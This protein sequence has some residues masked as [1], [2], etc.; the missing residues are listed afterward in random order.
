MDLNNTPS[1]SLSLI[2]PKQTKLVKI[3]GVNMYK[4]PAIDVVFDK[5]GNFYSNKR[6]KGFVQLLGRKVHYILNVDGKIVKGNTT[7]TSL[8][9]LML[10]IDQPQT[11]S[12]PVAK[13][14][15]NMFDVKIDPMMKALKES[16][17]TKNLDKAMIM[18]RIIMIQA[19]LDEIKKLVA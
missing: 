12:K 14:Q 15:T 19:S 4:N 7:K 2:D 8:H 13:K 17:K 9:R 16:S 11:K 1:K 3:N 6:Q 18:N 10:G 5:D